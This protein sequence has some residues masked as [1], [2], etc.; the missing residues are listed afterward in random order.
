MICDF[1]WEGFGWV[2]IFVKNK[3][4]VWF[5]F[6]WIFERLKDFLEKLE[7]LRNKFDFKDGFNIN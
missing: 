6:W 2:Q 1:L 5:L 7:E 3:I 4:R